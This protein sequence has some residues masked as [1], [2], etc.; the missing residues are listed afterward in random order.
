MTRRIKWID[1]DRADLVDALIAMAADHN[2][3]N[4]PE[5]HALEYVHQVVTARVARARRAAKERAK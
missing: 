3:I 4:P 5:D 2:P 1:A